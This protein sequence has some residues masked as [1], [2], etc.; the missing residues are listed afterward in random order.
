MNRHSLGWTLLL[1]GVALAVLGAIAQNPK[2]S[3]R[4]RFIAA[5][6]EGQLVQDLETGLFHYLV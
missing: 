5:T 6:A 4:L 2:T 3:P 1:S